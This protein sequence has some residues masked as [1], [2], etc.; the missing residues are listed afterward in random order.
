MTAWRGPVILA[1]RVGELDLNQL[2]LSP[3]FQA[4]GGLILALVVGY[5]IST[6]LAG[7]L[8]RA[9]AQTHRDLDQQLLALMRRPV[10]LTAVIVAL[11]WAGD[12]LQL[13]AAEQATFDATLGTIVVV[14]WATALVRA[15]DEVLVALLRRASS[16]QPELVFVRGR[17][18]G[19]IHFFVRIVVL[20]AGLYLV[21]VL[22]GLDVRA[23]QI[24][25]GVAGAVL[26]F[27]AQDSLG[28]LISAVFLVGDAPLRIG[29]Y[30]QVDGQMRGRVTDIGWRSTRILTNDGVE[31]NLPNAQLGAQRIIN[32]S[33]GPHQ[34][35]RLACEFAVEYGRTPEEVRAAVLP[36]A[37]ALPEL[38][39]DLPAELQFRGPTEAGLRFALVVYLAD[40]SRRTQ[41]TDVT[42]SHI[43]R[44]LRAAG[45]GLAY[46]S[47]V[48]HVGGPLA[49]ALQA[50]L[51]PGPSHMR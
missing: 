43:L 5:A 19:L 25:A 15:V 38:R 12:R 18:A 21:M 22:W 20:L 42:N 33:A 4:A 47:H 41:G 9:A 26:G 45:I 1:G 37:A 49:T 8:A 23:W 32:E 35:I 44:A 24:S 34:A 2:L 36:G 13:A 40:P 6:A 48:V 29:D 30:V 39:A 27:A 10:W 7:A 46:S 31:V 16:G 14:V 17:A 11:E 3:E 51:V 28:N 50:A